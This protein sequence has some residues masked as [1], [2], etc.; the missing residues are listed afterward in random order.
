MLQ[1][2]AKRCLIRSMERFANH[3]TAGV[4]PGDSSDGSRRV[5]WGVRVAANQNIALAPLGAKR[6][7]APVLEKVMG[8]HAIV[9]SPV[10]SS[11]SLKKQSYDPVM[12]SPVW[13][14]SAR[15]GTR[16]TTR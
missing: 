14:L 13:G 11:A 7:G 2:D 8:P 12:I 16:R 9:R 3:D 15:P 5:P 1:T 4:L 10:S 6:Q